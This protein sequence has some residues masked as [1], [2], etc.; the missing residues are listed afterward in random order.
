MIPLIIDSD[1]FYNKKMCSQI[2]VQK[3]EKLKNCNV[4]LYLNCMQVIPKTCLPMIEFRLYQLLKHSIHIYSSYTYDIIQLLT[5]EAESITVLL[6][7]I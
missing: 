5:N 2:G 6:Y 7:N 1:K 3:F 4:L